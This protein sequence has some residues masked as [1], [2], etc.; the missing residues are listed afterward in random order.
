[1]RQQ[2]D[3]HTEVILLTPL[4]AVHDTAARWASPGRAR[5]AVN[6][7]GVWQVS[8]RARARVCVCV[9]LLSHTLLIIHLSVCVCVCHSRTCRVLSQQ[10][11]TGLSLKVAVSQQRGEKV[12]KLERLLEGTNL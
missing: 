2:H 4:A 8:V 3:I 1:M 11:H 7:S 9:S 10:Q 5:Q 12:T 6:V